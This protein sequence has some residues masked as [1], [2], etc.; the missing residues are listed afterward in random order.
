[1]K[2]SAT[3]TTPE[4]ADEMFGRGSE[5]AMWFRAH[6]YRERGEIDPRK[7]IRGAVACRKIV[8]SR[9]GD[10]RTQ[11][12]TFTMADGTTTERERW[13]MNGA[14]WSGWEANPPK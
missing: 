5:L 6:Y 13:S 14:W 8:E 3:I 2:N 1:M 7:W 4:E 9:D 10:K 12:V 11:R